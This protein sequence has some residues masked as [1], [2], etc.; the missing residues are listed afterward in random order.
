MVPFY[1]ATLKNIYYIIHFIEYS[2]DGEFILFKYFFRHADTPSLESPS[3]FSPLDRDRLHLLSLSLF[4][5]TATFLRPIVII[6][7]H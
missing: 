4:S 3:L 1:R 2:I 7:H 6:L 5:D